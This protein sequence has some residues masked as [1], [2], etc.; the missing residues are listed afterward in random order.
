MEVRLINK[1]YEDNGICHA[2]RCEKCGRELNPNHYDGCSLLDNMDGQYLT[3]CYECK[4]ALM[5]EEVVLPFPVMVT[6]SRNLK[7][8]MGMGNQWIERH[9]S[10]KF[11]DGLSGCPHKWQRVDFSSH[12]VYLTVARA[13]EEG[14]NVPQ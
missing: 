12:T 2:D 7:N 14:I 11:F 13:K 4:T 6:Y 8:A 9:P 10:K 1:R 3:V 5:A